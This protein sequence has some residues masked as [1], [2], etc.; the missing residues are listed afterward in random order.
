[1]A[2]HKVRIETTSNRHILFIPHSC[3]WRIKS[4]VISLDN[5]CW[6]IDALSGCNQ[7]KFDSILFSIAENDCTLIFRPEVLLHYQQQN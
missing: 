3:A 5:I 7:N 1:M 6:P 2:Q 4:P